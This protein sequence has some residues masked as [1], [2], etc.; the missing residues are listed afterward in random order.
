MTQPAWFPVGAEQRLA[1]QLRFLP[2]CDDPPTTAL[3]LDAAPWAAER[4]DEEGH[5]RRPDR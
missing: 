1:G 2:R 4:P 3:A 5:E